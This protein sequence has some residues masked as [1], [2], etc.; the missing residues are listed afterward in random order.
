MRSQFPLFQSHIDL[1]HTYWKQ[2]VK[3]DDIV[4]DATCGNGYDTLF[5]GQLGCI[6]TALDVQKEAIETTRQR[7]QES[8]PYDRVQSISFYH[9]CHSTFPEEIKQASVKLIVYNLGYLPGGDKTKTTMGNSTLQSLTH[10]LSLLCSGGI[11]S[12]TCYPGHAEGK[13]EAELVD[14]FVMGL[15]PMQWSCCKHSWINRQDAPILLIIQR[16]SN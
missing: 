7:I 10:A 9:Q 14:Q 8:L 5:L 15:D 16:Q 4:I 2:L 12:I 1:A 6:V 11:I 3:E 13:I